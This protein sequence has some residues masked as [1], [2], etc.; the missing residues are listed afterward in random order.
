MTETGQQREEKSQDLVRKPLL[1]EKSVT[2]SKHW[3]EVRDVMSRQV[4]TVS[5]EDMVVDAAKMMTER[6]ISCAVVVDHQGKMIGILTERD[7]LQ[8]VAAKEGD[9]SGMKVSQAMTFPVES[10]PPSMSVFEA[11]SIL[12]SKKIRRLPVTENGE[13]VGIMTQT[14]LTRVLASYGVWQTVGDVMTPEVAVAQQAE[15]VWD[16]AVCMSKRNV[17]CVVIMEG[18][19]VAGILTER[20][21]MKKIVAPQR[22]PHRLRLQEVMTS[23]VLCIES[24]QS[25]FSAIRT[26]EEKKIRRLVVMEGGKLFGVVTQTDIFRAMK[27]KL[28][29]EDAKHVSFLE[30]SENAIYTADLNGTTTYVNPAFLKIL[31]VED[32]K[33]LVGKEFLPECFWMDPKDRIKLMGQ[34]RRGISVEIKDLVLKSAKGKKIYTTLFW[35][36]T[37]N[38]HGE[39]NGNQGILYDITEKKE[40]LSLREA[41]EHL[42]K[43]NE[44]LQRLNE[45]KSDFVSMVTHELRT[46]LTV[47]RG[48]I[49]LVLA[50]DYGTVNDEQKRSLQVAMEHVDRLARMINNLLDLSKIEAGKLEL[51]C[52]W[53][54]LTAL[55]HHVN[56]SF[57]LKAKEKNIGLKLESSGEMRIYADEDRLIQVF[58]NLL[59]N[60]LK[61]TQQGEIR[62]SIVNKEQEF[63]C[64]V[65]DTGMGISQDEIGKIFEK[66]EQTKRQHKVP[67][68]GTGLGLSIT[69]EFVTMHG[70]KIWVTSEL[71]AG[72]QVHFTLPKVPVIEIYRRILK[73]TIRAAMEKDS[74]ASF[75]M[76]PVE[77]LPGEE[78]PVTP[79]L[80]NTV[81]QDMKAVIEQTLRRGADQ[82][83]R[84]E[85]QIMIVL[86]EC[87]K[88]NTWR[89]LERIQTSLKTFLRERRLQDRVKI[90]FVHATYPDDAGTEEDLLELLIQ[91]IINVGHSF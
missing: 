16:A 38:I 1:S 59:G 69:R 33:E 88:E 54:D 30:H 44:A 56:E 36:F 47:I 11:S 7:L 63:E 3:L 81:L 31:E 75:V 83:V 58:T 4:A 78:P 51:K 73:Q 68:K 48:R 50:Q 64:I 71:N 6:N 40:L 25:V 67:E 77:L 42:R 53:L 35:T 19:K 61:F 28:Q 32:R 15:S 22:D 21:V 23:P 62:I 45:L 39:V 79:H 41:E 27:Q 72:T 90:A 89:A 24:G 85:R 2:S 18:E 46:P 5:P 43:S 34:L 26:I 17:S 86:A 12:E 55:A 9:F 60:A 20:D 66:Y 29:E 82:V 65:S 57:S 13:L 70:G 52:D 10:V 14:D 8:R 84:G 80:W 76:M 91:K 74:R 37:K 49:D 87:S